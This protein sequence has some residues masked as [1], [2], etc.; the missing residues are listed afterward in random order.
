M[1]RYVKV[2]EKGTND[3]CRVLSEPFSPGKLAF[4]LLYIAHTNRR[5]CG[6]T[7]PGPGLTK[8]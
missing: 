3:K 5:Q 4:K 2:E 8:T 6:H 7:L 1:S